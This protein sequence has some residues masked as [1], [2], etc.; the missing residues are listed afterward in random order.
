MVWNPSSKADVDVRRAYQHTRCRTSGWG[1]FWAG[2]LT[3]HHDTRNGEPVSDKK[4]CPTP[5]AR[6]LDTGRCAFGPGVPA[7]IVR[8]SLLPAA[9][10][11]GPQSPAWTLPAHCVYDA[12]KEASGHRLQATGRPFREELQ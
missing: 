6:S 9:C 1:S 10:Y 7:A 8:R 4:P 5:G 2:T 11:S 12:F 3:P